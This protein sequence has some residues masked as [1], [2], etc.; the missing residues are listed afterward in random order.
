MS[1]AYSLGIG[2]S[3]ADHDVSSLQVAPLDLTLP[4]DW[5]PLVY[6]IQPCD[7]RLVQQELGNGNVWLLP[8]PSNGSMSY[9]GV[10][11][12][13]KSKEFRRQVAGGWLR[14]A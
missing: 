12:T 11:M 10:M 9:Q 4:W 5:V 7:C 14:R 6:D 3:S 13:T 8:G 1:S 2:I